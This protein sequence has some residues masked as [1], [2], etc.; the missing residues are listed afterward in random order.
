MSTFDELQLDVG[1]VIHIPA[2]CTLP[3]PAI[4]IHQI[5]ISQ[6]VHISASVAEGADQVP[7][8]MRQPWVLELAFV[9]A[10]AV[11]QLK[12]QCA[13]ECFKFVFEC[14]VQ[15]Q[16][17][18]QRFHDIHRNLEYGQTSGRERVCPNVC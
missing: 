13:P 11:T 7:E 3:R 12:E 10:F 8:H 2:L 6:E 4:S 14:L 5:R 18:A 17:L 15:T 9:T 1:N 16:N